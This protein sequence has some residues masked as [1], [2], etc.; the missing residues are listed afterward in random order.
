M[1]LVSAHPKRAIKAEWFE[2]LK[3]KKSAGL[4]VYVCVCVGGG[5]AGARGPHSTRF[6]KQFSS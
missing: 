5:G 2:E 1:V 4:C 3:D 6:K